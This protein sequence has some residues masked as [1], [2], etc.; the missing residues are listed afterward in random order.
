MKTIYTVCVSAV[1]GVILSDLIAL[2]GAMCSENGIMSGSGW[3]LAMPSTFVSDAFGL[4][5]LPNPYIV[6][7][8]LGAIGFDIM[9]YLWNLY[10]S[11]SGTN[12]FGLEWLFILPA[13]HL[14][15]GMGLSDRKSYIIADI[16]SAVL[17]ILIVIFR[18]IFKNFN[19]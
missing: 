3:L 2:W 5:Y 8:F 18:R 1:I 16:E 7:G 12:S 11:K 17:F 19:F 14:G 6:N 10:I 4:G 9:S 13:T 15:G